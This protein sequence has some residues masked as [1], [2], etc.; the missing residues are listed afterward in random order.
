MSKQASFYGR[1]DDLRWL[2]GHF[3]EVAAKDARGKHA[4]PRLVVVTGPSGY[5]KSRLLQEFYLQL[6]QDH[7]LDPKDYW[8]DTFI[9][10]EG[11]LDVEA[12]MVAHRPGGLPQFL[13]LGHR[14]GGSAAGSPT[15]VSGLSRQV[16]IH[17]QLM[18]QWLRLKKR[19]FQIDWLNEVANW[20]LD[21]IPY[22]KYA[23]RFLRFLQRTIARRRR[24]TE[25]P[26]K[27]IEGE[28]TVNRKELIKSMRRLLSTADMAPTVLW[29]DDAHLIQPDDLKFL[30]DLFHVAKGESW[31]LLVVA[32]LWDNKW[33][34]A[35]EDG[36]GR[37]DTIGFWS[38]N[39]IFHGERSLAQASLPALRGVLL[40]RLPGLNK[41]QADA[42]LHKSSG[43]F[44]LLQW[45]IDELCAEPGNFIE[46]NPSK[47]LSKV[48]EK[49]VAG[50]SLDRKERAKEHFRGLEESRKRLLGLGS[51]FE[52]R[53]LMEIVAACGAASGVEGD[54]AQLLSKCVTPAC[55]LIRH[56]QQTFEFRDPPY[57]ERAKEYFA[58]YMCGEETD[59][60][61]RFQRA[62]R[63]H[64]VILVDEI[65][66]RRAR[67]EELP[68]H[69]ATATER[70][71]TNDEERMILELAS[72][73]R[74]RWEEIGHEPTT[75]VRAIY[76]ALR[77]AV[78]ESRISQVGQ[79]ADSL[80]TPA[81]LEQGSKG[82][83]RLNL[84]ALLAM[85]AS[86]LQP[87][88]RHLLALDLVRVPNY[89]EYALNLGERMLAAELGGDSLDVEGVLKAPGNVVDRESANRMLFESLLARAQVRHRLASEAM[90]PSGVLDQ[91]SE[92]IADDVELTWMLLDD[93]QRLVDCADFHIADRE[94]WRA[95][96]LLLRGDI[97][98][99][100]NK[101]IEAQHR[102]SAAKRA[103]RN[104]DEDSGLRSL[105]D[106]A[107]SYK[108]AYASL[109][110]CSMP[111]PIA[112]ALRAEV[113]SKIA[114]VFPERKLG[115]A[116]VRRWHEQAIEERE[117]LLAANHNE[118]EILGV[119]GAIAELARFMRNLGQ[120]LAE[121]EPRLDRLLHL[122]SDP[123]VA[124]DFDSC[125]W[126]A[127]AWKCKVRLRLDEV[128]AS[129]E[130][131]KQARRMLAD[132]I[133]ILELLQR[134]HDGRESLV[135]ELEEAQELQRKLEAA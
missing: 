78:K 135:K 133:A 60:E 124:E 92:E 94:L 54:T 11:M 101:Y 15:A 42:V 73:A 16:V 64:L 108:K 87:H 127:L 122:A 57:I 31:P 25:P 95:K 41:V 131:L 71:F 47:A 113:C 44:L 19:L 68:V 96:V 111:N 100:V 61:A 82:N 34:E 93:A 21:Q 49:T 51:Q 91:R 29:L 5:G 118:G 33:K 56:P 59:F 38:Q 40:E 8:P 98:H 12:C 129:T 26:G 123:L 106:P 109:E 53:F 69:E 75:R 77:Q 10:S 88:E 55:L 67:E 1:E 46:K 13:W 105:G 90:R 45:N 30:D 66:A 72:Q 22:S 70:R 112:T 2:R 126:Q 121:I 119:V 89:N 85:F 79:I 110:N 52:Q 39:Q 4:S 74:W 36:H 9:A 50:W 18:D 6:S 28:N 84:E 103:K 128:G 63:D 104:I 134:R 23:L 115:T 97:Q 76:L 3:D 99:Q 117:Q 120:P 17:A 130:Q 43:N 14:C 86:A 24:P 65:H 58:T 83:E 7:R 116:E 80:G 48:G 107:E 20:L 102:Q 114:A 37:A 35:T 125:R 81:T 62:V 132:A 32:T 27:I